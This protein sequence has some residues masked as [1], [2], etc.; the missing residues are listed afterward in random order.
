MINVLNFCGVDY[1]NC[2]HV[3]ELKCAKVF[4]SVPQLRKAIFSFVLLNP[5]SLC[6]IEKEAR[7][8]RRHFDIN[9]L[10]GPH[11]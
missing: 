1:N 11:K 8:F 6:V 9:S 7:V 3:S 4:L 10:I 5:P 2:P